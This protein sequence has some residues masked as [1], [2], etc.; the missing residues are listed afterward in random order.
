MAGVCVLFTHSAKVHT[1]TG[2][3]VFSVH[4][5]SAKVHIQAY[6][7]QHTQRYSYTQWVHTEIYCRAHDDV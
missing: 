1:T 4:T 2:V 3:C 5:H 7:T 6:N